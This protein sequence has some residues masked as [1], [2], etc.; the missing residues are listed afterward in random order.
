MAAFLG[1]PHRS[2]EPPV[3]VCMQGSAAL[4]GPPYSISGGSLSPLLLA[5]MPSSVAFWG[6][7][8]HDTYYI[9]TAF[10]WGSRTSSWPSRPFPNS[11]HKLP[12]NQ[13]QNTASGLPGTSDPVDP[14]K[15]VS[16]QL[17]SLEPRIEC[18]A[19]S[20]AT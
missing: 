6:V 4:A 7:P 5:R 10:M 2:G 8:W 19:P 9:Y 18:S 13:L 17:W 12:V 15:F 20:T 16:I 1:L 3:G 14:S 11:S